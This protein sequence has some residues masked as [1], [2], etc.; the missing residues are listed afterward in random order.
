MAMESLPPA[1]SSRKL[2]A[3]PSCVLIV[4]NSI[5]QETR[6]A[7]IAIPTVTTWIYLLDVGTANVTFDGDGIPAAGVELEEALSGA[8]LLGD[9]VCVNS[10]GWYFMR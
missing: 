8:E 10:K 9:A 2:S 3:M 4:Q 7:K 6:T 5:L 1:L